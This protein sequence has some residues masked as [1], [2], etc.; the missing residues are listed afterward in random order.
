MPIAPSAL[1]VAATRSPPTRPS[2][3]RIRSRAP[4]ASRTAASPSTTAPGIAADASISRSRSQ[5][6]AAAIVAGRAAAAIRPSRSDARAR[7]FPDLLLRVR[8]S[9]SCGADRAADHADERDERERVREGREEVR[10]DVGL[11]LERDRDRAREA[12]QEPGAERPERVPLAEDDRGERNE[13]APCAHV[14][15]ERAG[16]PDREVRAAEGREHP[17]E[18]DRGVAHLEYGDTDGVG[19]LRM[20]A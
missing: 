19:C 5:T 2:V 20:L 10:G 7:P 13:S 11:A 4:R 16:E 6:S 3:R 15:V 18:D 1:P 9:N 14:L 17:G 8:P 12:E